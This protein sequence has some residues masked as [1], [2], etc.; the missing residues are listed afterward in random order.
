VLE[1]LAL[2]E[3]RV[4]LRNTY[5]Y[6]KPKGV[7]RFVLP[8]LEKLADEYLNS[9]AVDASITFM[10]QSY[11]GRKKRA[12]NLIEF[13]GDWIGHSNHLWMWDFKSVGSELENIGFQD[14]RRARFGDSEET[15]FSYVEDLGRWEGSLGVECLK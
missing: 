7:F 1:H 13:I 9:D 8:D 11:L 3:F 12:S 15:H 5:L 4:A 10:E 2:N 14:I 6:L